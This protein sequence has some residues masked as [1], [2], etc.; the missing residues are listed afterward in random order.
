MAW[1]WWLGAA[2]LLA[3]TEIVSLD[4]VLIMFAAGAL[5]GGILAALGA[6]LWAQIVAAALTSGL[7]LFALRPWMLANLRKRTPLIETNTAAQVGRIGVVVSEVTERAG[8]V[9]LFGEVWTART[10]NDEVLA[11]GE[12]A[13]VVSIVGATAVVTAHHDTDHLG[14]ARTGGDHP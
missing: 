7:L 11:V 5:V 4:L 3:V 10:E 9:K 2:L 8:R 12:E 1:L 14:R 6:P 13:K